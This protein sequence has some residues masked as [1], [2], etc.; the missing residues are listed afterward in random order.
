[1]E[2]FPVWL[3]SRTAGWAKDKQSRS[4][5]KQRSI[6][7]WRKVSKPVGDAEKSKPMSAGLEK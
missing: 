1:M 5:L 2:T 3:T 4:G 7:N 6:E